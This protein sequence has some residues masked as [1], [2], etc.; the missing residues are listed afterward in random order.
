M[1]GKRTRITILPFVLGFLF[2]SCGSGAGSHVD[3]SWADTKAG[4]AVSLTLTD[5]WETPESV[6]IATSGW[7]DGINVSRDGLNLYA[8][9]IPAD[10]LSF[11]LSGDFVD[12]LPL[13]QR[14][15]TYAMDF[16]G[17]SIGVD[18]TWLHSDIIYAHRSST[19]ED[20]GSWQ[21]SSMARAVFSEGA[22]TLVQDGSGDIDIMAFTSNEDSDTDDLVD[23][24]NNF[25]TISDTSADPVSS[26]VNDPYLT[27]VD[28]SLTPPLV[29]SRYTEDNPHLERL[30]ASTLVL[31]FDSP[32]RPGGTGDID[33]WY[34]TSSDNGA[35]WTTPL[36]VTSI[37]TVSKE[38]QPHL[39]HD[40]SSWWLYYS[41][42][43]SDGKLAI[44][45]AQQQ[46]ASWDDWGS[47]ELVISAG[48]TGGVGEPTLTDDG[49][50]F[51]VVILDNSEGSSYDRYDGDPWM[52]IHK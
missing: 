36:P 34:S 21:L 39:F 2:S 51:F 15:P 18:Y 22:V 31:F 7:E 41:A 17:S 52:A 38:H 20:F 35:N 30:D 3:T 19:A 43:H 8:T 32:D 11:T 16:D 48:N 47:P 13:Y 12:Q 50:L 1:K 4:A 45:R 29:N 9:Y 44:F 5:E 33:I 23:E 28:T 6:S 40:G 24:L 42:Y 37:N 26:G 25:R 46:T 49:D 14:G 10:F 27:P